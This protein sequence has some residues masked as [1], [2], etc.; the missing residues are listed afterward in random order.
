MKT[1]ELYRNFAVISETSFANHESYDKACFYQESNSFKCNVSIA[2]LGSSV[3][4]WQ[5]A[6]LH[7]S[8]LELLMNGEEVSTQQ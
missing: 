4:V 1:A 7:I 8:G 2:S 6:Q 5:S 3:G